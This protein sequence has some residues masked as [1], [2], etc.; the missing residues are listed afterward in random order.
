MYHFITSWLSLCWTRYRDQSWHA[1]EMH[2]V[3]SKIRVNQLID[4][5]IQ[6]PKDCMKQW[7]LIHRARIMS[8]TFTN[9]STS[10]NNHVSPLPA[11]LLKFKRNLPHLNLSWLLLLSYSIN[12]YFKVAE[13]IWNSELQFYP[14]NNSNLTFARPLNF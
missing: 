5:L 6:Q 10:R 7:N 12:I 13:K 2:V 3:I 8:W 9:H 11:I 1:I 4:V 14:N